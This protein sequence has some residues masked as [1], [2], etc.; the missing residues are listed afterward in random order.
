MTNDHLVASL[1]TSGVL[2]RVWRCPAAF[3]GDGLQGALLSL[4]E[5]RARQW[6]ATTANPAATRLAALTWPNDR[7]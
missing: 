5:Q 4:A 2:M 1:V 7:C 3:T 6:L